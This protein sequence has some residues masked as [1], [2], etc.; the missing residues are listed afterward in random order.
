MK[1]IIALLFCALLSSCSYVQCK[2]GLVLR[3]TKAIALEDN[4][5]AYFVE[6]TSPKA[7]VKNSL[8]TKLSFTDTTGKY[9]VG[10]VLFSSFDTKADTL[11]TYNY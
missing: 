2:G 3:I 4:M 9:K 11:E 5:T 7:V 1:L 10:Q 8:S 6:L